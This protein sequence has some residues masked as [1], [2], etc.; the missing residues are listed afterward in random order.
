VELPTTHRYILH[1]K[2]PRVSSSRIFPTSSSCSLHDGPQLHAA[3][4]FLK[5]PGRSA[6]QEF[7]SSLYNQKGHYRVPKC[8][9][10]VPI[11]SQENPVHTSQFYFS[12]SRDSVVGIETAYGLDDRGVG[13]RVPVGP[14]IFFFSTSSRPALGSTQP[15]IQ[16]VPGALSTGVKRQGREAD[17][18]PPASDEVKKMWIYIS[19]PPYAF[20]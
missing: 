16:W 11:L 14:R 13:V 20:M 3:E 4:S 5:T 1:S 6:T 17:H 15:L 8:P 12:R 10:L 2:A 18:S 19:T 9:P 7:P